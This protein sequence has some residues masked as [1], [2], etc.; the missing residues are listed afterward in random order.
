M[1]DRTKVAFAPCE[2]CGTDLW[3]EHYRGP[4]RAGA[5]GRRVEDATIGLCGGCGVQRLAE[6]HCPADDYYVTAE[7][8]R[9]LKQGTTAADFVKQG[10]GLQI[11]HLNA[12]SGCNV[13]DRHIADIGAAAGSFLDH[14]R[15]LAGR[16]TA[17]EPAEMYHDWLAARGHDV[18]SSLAGARDLAGTVD[19]AVSFHVIE[20]VADPRAFLADMATVLAPGGRI[21]IST[22]NRDDILMGLLPDDYPAFFY[23]VAHRWYFNADSLIACAERAG[24]TCQSIQSVQRYGLSNTLNWLKERRPMGDRRLPGI[25]ALADHQWRAYLQTM[26][27]ADTLYAWLSA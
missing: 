16:T 23:R 1:N 3:K 15:G 2:V 20:H 11:L 14:V 21:L 22:P 24:L 10:D 19:L 4:I 5:F 26:G 27:M 6:I 7:Y 13:R 17:I 9:S 18:R 12:L 25:E 8:R